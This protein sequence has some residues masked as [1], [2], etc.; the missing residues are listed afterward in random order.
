MTKTFQVIVFIQMPNKTKNKYLLVKGKAGFGNRIES[1]L[2]SILYAKLCGR[3]LYVDW[4]DP[5]YSDGGVNSFHSFFESPLVDPN[6]HFP[7]THSVKPEIW[8]GHLHKSIKEME[9]ILGNITGPDDSRQKLSIDPSKLNYSEDL[10][11]LW[12]H[13]ERVDD[14]R[15]HLKGQYKQIAYS[16]TEDILKGLLKENLILRSEIRGRVDQFRR[17]RF[18]SEMIGLHIRYTDMKIDL[19]NILQRLEAVFKHTPACQIFLATDNEQIKEDLEKSYPN[20]ITAPHWYAVSG[21]HIHQNSDCPDR[22][23]NGI[24]ALVDLYLLAEC[25]YLIIDSRSR[26][27]NLAKLLSKAPSSRIFDVNRTRKWRRRLRNMILHL[28]AKLGWYSLGLRIIN[29]CQWIES[30]LHL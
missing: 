19:P 27:A 29:L 11:V 8:K 9:R 28:S 7:E 12:M 25:D 1:L 6:D 21:S 5:T 24:E 13:L 30:R 20:V 16:S 10:L 26:F 17:E 4:S 22:I 3:R 23:E 18:N 14:L 2:T 15:G